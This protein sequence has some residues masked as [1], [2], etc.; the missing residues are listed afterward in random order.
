M[1]FEQGE[2]MDT[3]TQQQET[4]K[5]ASHGL[6]VI[7]VG[8]IQEKWDLSTVP[9][10]EIMEKAGVTEIDKFVLE[11]LNHKGGDPVAEFNSNDPVDLSVKDRKF[12]RVTPGG[13]GRS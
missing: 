6:F 3:N 1:Q 8:D 5:D 2:D 4:G 11:A 12:F 9:A 13:G 7:F 10:K